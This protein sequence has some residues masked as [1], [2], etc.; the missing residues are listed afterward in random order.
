M[1][2]KWLVFILGVLIISSSQS[3]AVAQNAQGSDQV[4]PGEERGNGASTL[5]FEQQMHNS[6]EQMQ[7]AMGNVPMTGDPDQDFARMMIPHH[8]GAITMAEAVLEKGSDPKIRKMAQ[9]MV[10]KQ[11]QEIEELQSWLEKQGEATGGHH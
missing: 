2:A 6:M 10:E 5:T 8:Q 1:R 3:S 9:E 11:K 7:H 4:A